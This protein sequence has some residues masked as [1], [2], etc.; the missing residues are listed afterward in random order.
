MEVDEEKYECRGYNHVCGLTLHSSHN[1]RQFYDVLYARSVTKEVDY[2]T[3]ASNHPETETEIALIEEWIAINEEV[4]F[5]DFAIG[6]H[7]S[8]D[9][10]LVAV[11]REFSI[12]DYEA[13]H[14]L[15]TYED[16]YD[17]CSVRRRH[18]CI[19]GENS[20]LHFII[21]K[22]T[23]KVLLVGSNCIKT[24]QMS[25]LSSSQCVQ[26]GR[27]TRCADCVLDPTFVVGSHEGQHIFEVATTNDVVLRCIKDDNMFYDIAVRIAKVVRA[28]IYEKPQQV[29]NG[30]MVFSGGKHIG[31]SFHTVYKNHPDYADWV[32]RVENPT[33]VMVAFKNYVMSM[34]N[35]TS[36]SGQ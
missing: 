19:C 26:C 5:D 18:H 6:K 30:N 34:A 8:S 11:M 22:N 27:S 28:K 32:L 16:I 33:G 17:E 24:V 10:I 12:S 4:N 36:S 35:I 14:L 9:R 20:K 29:D 2:G 21:N 7:L 3:C 1:R 15:S 23:K 31:K 13:I 25:S